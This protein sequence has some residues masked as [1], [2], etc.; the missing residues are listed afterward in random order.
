MRELEKRKVSNMPK[1][2][3]L[4]THSQNLNPGTLESKV[5]TIA[6]Q[7]ASIS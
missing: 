4:A 2:I 7:P 5:L 1:V 3:Q 6:W